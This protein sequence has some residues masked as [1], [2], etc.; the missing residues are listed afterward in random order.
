MFYNTIIILIFIAGILLRLKAYFMNAPLWLDE[1][2]LA[3]NIMH[4]GIFGYFTPLEHIQSAP[5]LFMM[6]TKLVTMLFGL[7]EYT[8]R[9]IPLIVSIAS[10][11]VFYIFSKKFLDKKWSIIVA[12]L[13][14]AINFRLIYFA[15]EFKQYASDVLFFMLALLF[16][17]KIELNKISFKKALLTGFICFLMLLCSMPSMFVIGAFVIYNL[18]PLKQGMGVG[19]KLF[20]FLL[21][22]FIFGPFYYIY[23]LHPTKQA[24]FSN[25]LDQWESGFM[26]YNP[27]NIF[28]LLRENLDYLFNYT[29]FILFGIILLVTGIILLIKSRKKISALMLLVLLLAFVA[30]FCNIFPIKNRVSVYI[31]VPFLICI[32]KP[33]DIVSIKN[34]ISSAVVMLLSVLFFSAYNLTYA[35]SLIFEN[36]I[37]NKK[38]GRATMEILSKKFKPD[39]VLVYND[40][41]NS[42]YDYYSEQSGMYADKIIRINLPKYSRE[43]YLGLL[44]QL[45]KNH[46]Y[47]FYYANDYVK[48]P[49][50]PFIKEW[51]KDKN[52][53][54]EHYINESYLLHLKL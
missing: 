45:P 13:I 33:L 14:F 21:P 28:P 40:A 11:F 35:K 49:V 7:N 52:V 30:S 29:P 51:I 53:L 20:G 17:S 10:I 5:P 19:R 54:E 31:I 12:N 1:C 48:M 22:F 8:L 46:T 16:L 50:L 41:T 43:F 4:R 9:L 36:F 18:K 42:I 23:N 44:E 25:F 37:R 26:N 2:S 38:D 6:A 34:K 27:L 39:E 47:W 24:M 15:E 32:I 3:L